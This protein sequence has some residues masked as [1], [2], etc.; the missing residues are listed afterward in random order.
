MS[1]VAFHVGEGGKTASGFARRGLHD[2]HRI[3]AAAYRCFRLPVSQHGVEVAVVFQWGHEA[4]AI[5]RLQHLLQCPQPRFQWCVAGFAT[6]LDA[7]RIY[8][9]LQFG[10][11]FRETRHE[12]H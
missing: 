9:S 7:L 5:A 8:T 12:E 1:L 2:P 11:Q 6:A 4:V 3:A 10:E